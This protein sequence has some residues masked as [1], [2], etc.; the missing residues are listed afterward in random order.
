VANAAGVQLLKT[1]GRRRLRSSMLVIAR[2]DGGAI[3]E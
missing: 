2:Q 3:D 1:P